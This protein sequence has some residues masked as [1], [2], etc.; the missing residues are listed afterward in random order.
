MRSRLVLLAA[1][2]VLIAFSACGDDGP[3]TNMPTL[4]EGSPTSGALEGDGNI[5]GVEVIDDLTN[6]H[7]GGRVDYPDAPPAG[8]D[9]AQA[10]LNCGVYDEPVPVENAVHAL[11]HGVV[12]FAHDPE[13]PDAD[14]DL[15]HELAEERPDRVI[16]SPYPD[17]D[18]PVVAVAW[19][20]RLEVDAA[21]DPRLADFLDAF[22]DGEAAPEPGAP[23]EGGLG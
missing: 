15:L 23:C 18:A 10:W 5:E 7:V 14:V 2:P 6:D 21:D 9:H 13:L 17:I 8:G 11:E 20:R 16:V 1:A 19:G 3:G 12:W 22:V 4:D